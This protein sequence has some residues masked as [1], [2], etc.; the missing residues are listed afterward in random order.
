M[1]APLAREVV[2]A[3]AAQVAALE[4]RVAG[5]VRLVGLAV[6]AAAVALAAQPIPLHTTFFVSEI[7][8]LRTT[9]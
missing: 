7:N 6:P 8:R 4:E 9:F 5:A 2:A 1:V 3:Q